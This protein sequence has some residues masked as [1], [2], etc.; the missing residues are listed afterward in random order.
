MNEHSPQTD[1]L[2]TKST[3]TITKSTHVGNRLDFG[4]IGRLLQLLDGLD[5]LVDANQIFLVFLFLLLGL[6]CRLKLLGDGTLLFYGYQGMV[7]TNSGD[8]R[9]CL[10][11]LLQ[12]CRVSFSHLKTYLNIKLF[13]ATA[14]TIWR[15]FSS[16]D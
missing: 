2:Q 11:F 12:N 4:R 6:P 13:V 8:K 1:S 16:N 14:M 5:E 7:N 3:F 9:D 10:Y 15:S